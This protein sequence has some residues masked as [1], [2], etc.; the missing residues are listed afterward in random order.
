MH[1]RFSLFQYC[2][3]LFTKKFRK[4]KVDEAMGL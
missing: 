2:T 4:N 3:P 1:L